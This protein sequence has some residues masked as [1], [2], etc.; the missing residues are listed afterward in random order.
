M[1]EK[2]STECQHH[3]VIGSPNGPTSTGI[4][5]LCGEQSEFRNSMQGSGW[6]REIQAVAPLSEA[7]RLGRRERV[8]QALSI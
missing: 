1:E 7:S 3:W 5:K 6:D 4:C 2:L 8:E